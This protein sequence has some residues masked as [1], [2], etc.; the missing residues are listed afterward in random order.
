M[1]PRRVPV[2]KE[3]VFRTPMTFS[4]RLDGQKAR[5]S[6]SRREMFMEELGLDSISDASISSGDEDPE[7][8][9]LSGPSQCSLLEFQAMQIEL[10]ERDKQRADLMFRIKVLTDKNKLYKSSLA[11]EEASKKQQ[12]L[13]MRKTHESHLDEKRELSKNLQDVIEE[14]EAKIFELE[15][16]L[17][18]VTAS[19]RSKKT[20]SGVQRLVEAIER[21]H[22]EKAQLTEK[23]FLAEN[24]I[25]NGRQEWQKTEEDLR[26]QLQDLNRDYNEVKV[27]LMKM[28]SFQGVT[29]HEK[30]LNKLEI[31]NARLQMELQETKSQ[32]HNGSMSNGVGETKDSLEIQ[33]LEDENS[34]LRMQLNALEK[35]VSSL[36]DQRNEKELELKS[37][38][39]KY[40][41]EIHLLEDK[42]R[43]SITELSELKANPKVVEVMKTVTVSVESEETKQAL[44]KAESDNST[45]RHEIEKMHNESEGYRQQLHAAENRMK[46]LENQLAQTEHQIDTVRE[47]FEQELVKMESVNEEVI[48]RVQ[49]ESQ[50]SSSVMS[51]KLMMMK[52]R[53]SQI[54]PGL[55]EIAEEYKSLRTICSQFPNIIRATVQHTKNEI[56][57]AISEVSEHNK[58]L[59]R[60]YRKEM[61]LRKKYHNEL[62]E[63]K[64][65]I[66]VFCRVRPPI[67]EDGVGLMARVVVTYDT[68]DDGIL[69][70]HNKGRTSSY[71]VDK[72]FTPA[73]VQQ[74]VFDEMKHLVISCIDG[75]NVCIFAYGQTGS[76]KTYTMEG[77]KNDRG[78]NQLSLQCLFAERKE[79]DK[80]WNYTI[81]VNVME[82]YNEM[83]RDLLSDDPTFK[84][85]IK[86]NQEGGLYVPGLI[87]LPVNSV[88]DV[89][90]L[91][92]TAKVNRATAST[93]MN[94]HSSRSHALLC[95]TVTGTN[96]T[97][98]N[99]TIGKLNLVDL[100]GSERVSKSG[101]DGARLKE[102]QNINKSL[103]SLGDVIHALRNKQAH[104]PYRNSKLTYL[105]QDSLGGDSKTLMVVQT[106]PVE[107]NVGETMSSLSFAQRVRAVELG[108]ATKKVESAEI[109]TLKGRLAQYEDVPTVSYSSPASK[110]TNRGTPNRST[111]RGTPRK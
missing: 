76:G 38:E 55:L 29:D 1:M 20:S 110:G 8:D 15:A 41:S 86:M 70:V 31:A 21:L 100:A 64:G 3:P 104:I 30:Q 97:T 106:S 22:V 111:P 72:V 10:D 4:P 57:H 26:S 48:R 32:V 90:R 42:L 34:K 62:V 61:S 2:S 7:A 49:L 28:K 84:L 66:R 43:Q 81:T 79:K 25:E 89:N 13:I 93:N 92:D 52:M 24:Q 17:K 44:S 69:Y 39:K 88:D 107:K 27:E 18:G 53:F 40:N 71:E 96:K 83:L 60:K 103:S 77:P 87:S 33:K 54:R 12:I 56:Q 36:T 59:V 99:R 14:Q 63:L 109:A 5:P 95:V 50:Q 80:E 23:V 11:K 47:E 35:D 98:G 46:E 105:L 68:D 37:L 108:Q 58:E 74:E 45:L 73:S 102:A 19:P 65:N 6:P 82:I 75:F 101:A 51:R 78:I 94:E 16:E 91:L 9:Q 67:K 85:D